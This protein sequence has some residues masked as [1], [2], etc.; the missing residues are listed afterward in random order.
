MLY[1][2]KW[3]LL[4][5][6]VPGILFLVIFLYVPFVENI[7]NA[8]YDMSVPVAMPGRA[9]RYVGAENFQKL[10]SD[11]M[12]RVALG[13]SIKMMFLT[14]I[15]EVGIAFVLAVLVSNIKKGQQFFR[16]VYFFPI[17]ISATAIGLLFKLFYNYDSGMLNQIL[18]A[19]GFAKVK[20]LGESLAFIMV[21]IPTLWSY[22]GFYFVILLT[23]LSDIPEEVYEA[24]SI[25]GCSKFKQVFYITMP[26]LRGV[27]CTCI[28]LAVTGALK[29]F[30]LPWVIASQGAPYGLTHF[31]G[32]Y[33][34]Q[35]TFEL[36]DY[37]Y[38]SAIAILIVILGVIVSK[39]VTKVARPDANM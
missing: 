17:V 29:V 11:P 5:F 10:F 6:L 15:F 12:I 9:F 8:L 16:T 31:M 4:I 36:N 7:K 21:C 26:M 3:P 27:F 39:I 13:N 22:V 38:G 30:D 33:M 25:D 28:T 20:W 19:L 23:G 32:T 35:T 1:K 37:G 24:A 14:V 34:Y 18:T 2:K